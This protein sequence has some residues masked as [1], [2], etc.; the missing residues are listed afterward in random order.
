MK[1][2]QSFLILFSALFATSCA[3][4]RKQNKPDEE[5]LRIPTYFSPNY[6][7][8]EKRADTLDSVKVFN[9]YC[10]NKKQIR[11]YRLSVL[12][13]FPRSNPGT[14][15]DSA[16]AQINEY[17]KSI[18]RVLKEFINT[19]FKL[20]GPRLHSVG[21]KVAMVATSKN[22]KSLVESF[23][24]DKR[25]NNSNSEQA[26]MIYLEDQSRLL[27]NF[28]PSLAEKEIFYSTEETPGLIKDLYSPA[29]PSSF[30]DRSY[31]AQVGHSFKPEEI[32]HLSVLSKKAIAVESQKNDGK[33]F[34]ITQV[35]NLE[36]IMLFDNYV[37]LIPHDIADGWEIHHKYK[38]HDESGAININQAVHLKNMLWEKLID[39]QTKIKESAT[40]DSRIFNYEA[41]VDLTLACTYARP[42]K[43]LMVE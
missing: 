29:A 9:F 23:K 2:F 22:S 32:N 36:K 38:L 1:L 43:D 24:S 15:I 39:S 7:Y 41:I 10:Q 33:V 5:I 11:E 21:D 40:E 27:M 37:L 18:P 25:Y 28:M 12:V 3:T 30:K 16:S 31:I 6:S 34:V 20:A 42:I 19:S 17:R 35:E 8:F 13:F 14:S 26:E 4:S